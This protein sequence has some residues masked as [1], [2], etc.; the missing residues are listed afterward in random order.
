LS[1]FLP[2]YLVGWLWHFLYEC[3]LDELKGYFDLIQL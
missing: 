1:W 2:H 3:M